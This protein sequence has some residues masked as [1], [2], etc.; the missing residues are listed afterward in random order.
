[1]PAA[2]PG[3][4]KVTNGEAST[5]GTSRPNGHLNEPIDEDADDIS[6]EDDEGSNLQVFQKIRVFSNLKSCIRNIGFFSYKFGYFC[7]TFRLEI[8]DY[9]IN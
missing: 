5:S 4:S 8:L 7:K 1:M 3:S 6:N 9:Q 2:V